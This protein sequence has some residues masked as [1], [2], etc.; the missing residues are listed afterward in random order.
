MDVETKIRNIEQHCRS[1][2]GD[3]DR[4]KFMFTVAAVFG[5]MWE[6]GEMEFEGAAI[7]EFNVHIRRIL[8]NGYNLASCLQFGNGKKGQQTAER[9]GREFSQSRSE[10]IQA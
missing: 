4:D 7:K 3:F 5:V 9:I 10:D 8:G 6:S 1:N 2:D